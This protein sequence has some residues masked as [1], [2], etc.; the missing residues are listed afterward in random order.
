MIDEL[1][2]VGFSSQEARVYVALLRQPSATGYELAKIAGLQRANVYQ[3]LATLAERD[4]V[5]QVSDSPARFLAKPPAMVLG[6]IKQETVQRCDS[7][8]VDL[9]TLARPAEPTA[10]W[11][12]RGRESVLERA[13]A[14]VSDARERIAVCLWADDLDW[15][16]T[17]LRAAAQSGCQVVVNVFGDVPVDFGDVY[18]HEP[19]AKT[20]GGHL[21]T[22]AVDSGTALIA[23]LDEPAGA[24]YTEHPALLRVVEKL[25]R[26][27]AYL[28][29]IYERLRP[30]LEETFGRHLVELRARLLPPDQADALMSV[31]GF[32]ADQEIVNDL[33]TE[34]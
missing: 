16:G 24:V 31:V 29:A 4:V 21:F 26:D 17:P 34:S 7:L 13:G 9:A 33:L 23:S 10:F 2:R 12:L 28:A 27:E 19:P 22:L 32:G 15:I 20:V 25:I 3:V 8:I 30:E 5:E 11:S 14:L 1:V 6:R 18:R